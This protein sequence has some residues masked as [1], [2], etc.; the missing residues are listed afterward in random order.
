LNEKTALKVIKST[1][2]N[3]KIEKIIA[4]MKKVRHKIIAFKK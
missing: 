1:S 2:F 3:F 4:G